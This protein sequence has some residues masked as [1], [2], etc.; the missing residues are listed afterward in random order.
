VSSLPP[1]DIADFIGTI[2][3]VE[4]VYP[5]ST[6]FFVYDALVLPVFFDLTDTSGGGCTAGWNSLVDLLGLLRMASGETNAVWVG[7]LP[8]GTPTNDVIGCGAPGVAI[9]FS[10]GGR[11]L[12]QEMAH[13]LGRDHAP[14]QTNAPNIDPNYPSYSGFPAGSI[15]ETGFDWLPSE[16]KDPATTSDFMTYCDPAWI[17]PYTSIGLI[18][19]MLLLDVGL[20]PL[21][22]EPAQE[23][24]P[25]V[26]QEVLLLNF[27]LHQS[28][29][30]E[31]LSSFHLASY[32]DV[33]AD[34]VIAPGSRPTAVACDLLDADGVVLESRR[35][36]LVNSHQG[37]DDPFIDFH[38][39]LRWHP[40]ARSV[41]FSQ[42]GRTFASVA[43][44][45]QEPVV[46]VQ[47]PIPVDGRPNMCKV[48][49]TGRHSS[50]RLG[51]L[52]RYS[53]DDGVSWR[54]ISAGSRTEAFVDLDYLPG[55][56]ACRFQVVASSGLRSV[57]VMT[58]SFPVAVH[59]Y[60]TFIVTPQQGS[61]VRQ[62]QPV[63]LRGG[64]F[65]PDFG[66]A[67]SESLEWSSNLDGVL[68]VGHELIVPNLSRGAHELRLIVLNAQHAVESASVRI[69]VR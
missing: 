40:E 66:S 68:G 14:C 37:A 62:L 49:W 48:V 19:G 47:A 43:V 11:T 60:R 58:D 45:D 61:V 67:G 54:A 9:A 65:S 36:S 31:V 6:P 1:P 18:F 59:P 34:D 52:L 33:I 32:G 15:G 27:R 30:V 64:A 35:C 51:Y 41:A 38:E 4:R 16:V 69:E 24:F 23:A 22:A 10:G 53:N 46:V 28:N 21:S 7:L 63:R 44:E 42:Y 50:H 2:D 3:W 56:E 5:T 17:S 39:V 8:S 55:G 57:S 25:S 12:A 26:A 29:R 20:Q 13:S